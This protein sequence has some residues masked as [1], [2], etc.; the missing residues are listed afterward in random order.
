MSVSEEALL[1]ESA[2]L[3]ESLVEWVS[4]MISLSVLLS[5]L[6]QPKSVKVVESINRCA[7]AMKFTCFITLTPIGQVSIGL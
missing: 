4:A 6:P 3:L 1:S 5:E 7:G 2:V